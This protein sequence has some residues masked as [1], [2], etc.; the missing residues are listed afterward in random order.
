MT[1][2]FYF[3]ISVTTYYLINLMLGSTSC[4]HYILYCSTWIWAVRG[5][6]LCHIITWVCINF[7][8]VRWWLL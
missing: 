5:W 2:P 1:E 4:S 7:L 3:V 6:I 8:V